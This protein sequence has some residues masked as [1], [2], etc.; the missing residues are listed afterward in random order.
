MEQDE[1]KKGRE[2]RGWK[3]D[4]RKRGGDGG[5]NTGERKGNSMSRCPVFS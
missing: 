4:K 2:E 5:R 1:K 3:M